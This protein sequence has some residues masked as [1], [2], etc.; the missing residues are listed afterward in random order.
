MRST[1]ERIAVVLSHLAYNRAIPRIFEE[2]ELLIYGKNFVSSY[3]N[4]IFVVLHT[5]FSV[6][7]SD[8]FAA[9]LAQLVRVSP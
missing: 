9:L 8:F 5:A 6:L 4:S 1:H 7:F 3:K 2:Q